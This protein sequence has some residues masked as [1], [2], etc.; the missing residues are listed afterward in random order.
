MISFH[1]IRKSKQKRILLFLFKCSFSYMIINETN[2]ASQEDLAALSAR[3]AEF[4]STG[5][6]PTIPLTLAAGSQSLDT[7][8]LPQFKDPRNI[9]PPAIRTSEPSFAAA[10]QEDEGEI[11]FT[12]AP[13]LFLPQAK[14]PLTESI[15]TIQS[16][17]VELERRVSPQPP[18][19]A[20]QRVHEH[21]LDL[22]SRISQLE[23]GI[24]IS[25]YQ[26]DEAPTAKLLPAASC[27]RCDESTERQD[28]YSN[29]SD[30]PLPLR[31]SSSVMVESSASAYALSSDTLTKLR[32]NGSMF[33][34]I[35]TVRILSLD[36]GGVRGLLE[37]EF[38]ASLEKRTNMHTTEI[39]QLM[40]G[41]SVG[42]EIVA[43]LN[44]KDKQTGKPKYS[45]QFLLD[46]FLKKYPIVFESK[47]K[48]LLGLFGEK[49]KTKPFKKIVQELADDA[50]YEEGIVPCFATAYDLSSAA[51]QKLTVFSSTDKSGLS[52]KDVILSTTAAPGY[53]KSHKAS[54]GKE[55]ADGGLIANNP[56]LIAINQAYKHYPNASKIVLVS[57]GTGRFVDVKEEYPSLRHVSLLNIARKIP[58]FFLRGQQELVEESLANRADVVRFRFNPIIRGESISLDKANPKNIFRLRKAALDNWNLEHEKIEELLKL[59]PLKAER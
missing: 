31:R 16:K 47:A 6:M 10:K 41:T 44:L 1:Q 59:L 21:L 13:S 14:D 25:K 48:T 52:T 8:M 49:Y 24:E 9:N 38:L 39:F 7:K 18:I 34:P 58:H 30:K 40:G 50:L 37:L 33:E 20:Q 17:V 12:P 35:T 32:L 45:A 43:L 19:P 2:A 4:Q 46:Y 28:L 29:P 3:E 11:S 53:F 27:M 23:R 51:G 56:T 26:A 54:N 55:Y 15:R 22:H 57:L 42:G 36:G 5:S